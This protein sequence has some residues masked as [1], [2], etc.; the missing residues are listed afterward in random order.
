MLTDSRI[1]AIS[2]SADA[3]ASR[4]ARAYASSVIVPESH[5]LST[6]AVSPDSTTTR[7]AFRTLRSAFSTLELSG[8]TAFLTS[9]DSRATFATTP[10]GKSGFAEVTEGP[11]LPM[12]TRP[13]LSMAMDTAYLQGFDKVSEFPKTAVLFPA[14]RKA[15]PRAPGTI[16]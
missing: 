2:L 6:R 13:H 7:S 10:P 5:S 16:S 11:T 15:S 8:P 9:R 1:P 12:S 4:L 14:L 3:K